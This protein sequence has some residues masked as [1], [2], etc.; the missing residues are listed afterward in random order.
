[1]SK[2]FF[3]EAQHV[4]RYAMT[5]P[6]YPPELMQN[7]IKFLSMKVFF[8]VVS[9]IPKF[10][11]AVVSYWRCIISFRDA[12]PPHSHPH[13][14]QETPDLQI[15]GYMTLLNIFRMILTYFLNFNQLQF[16]VFFI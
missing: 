11:D 8:R 12:H 1:M 2:R 7:I 6:S 13:L 9:H 3:E 15:A 5:R 4:A 10:G 16:I 14:L